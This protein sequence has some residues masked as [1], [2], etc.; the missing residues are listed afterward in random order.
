MTNSWKEWQGR[1][2]DGKF[3]LGT[4]LGGSEGSAVF[5]TRISASGS[6]PA[7][8]SPAKDAKS[9]SKTDAAIKLVVADG[10][11][12]ESPLQRWKVAMSLN[13]PNLLRILAVGRCIVDGREVVYAVEEFSEENL[14][15]V[16]S[17][18][19]LDADETRGTLLPVLAALEYVHGQGL[20]H[21][22]IRPSNILGVENQV[23]LSSDSLRPA[24]E[25]PRS[26]GLYDAPEV[27]TAGISPASDVWCFGMTMV[28]TLTQRVPV[29]DPARMSPPEIEG[30]I[31]SNVPEPF[32]GIAQRCLALD[33]AQRSGVREIAD[34]LRGEPGNQPDAKA[35][36]A[37]VP[38]AGKPARVA[39]IAASDEKTAKWPYLLLLAAAIAVAIFLI[40]R[41]RPSS[42]PSDI[43]SGA[44]NTQTSSAPPPSSPQASS[45]PASP[46]Q[47]GQPTHGEQQSAQSSPSAARPGNASN[48]SD[49]DEIVERATPQVAPS[50][51]RTISGKIKVRVRVVVDPAGNV[52]DAKLKEGGSSK[53]FARLA[54][55]AARRWKFAPAPDANRRDWILLFAFTRARTEMSAARAH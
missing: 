30:E 28:E 9:E 43:Q 33:P 21:G 1:T 25:V 26:I 27:L 36:S 3:V 44:P 10:A 55:E 17:T 22:A 54:V 40:V 5:R 15:Q 53:Y 29:W 14:S 2:V 12:S 46:T 7:G 50:A 13:H 20:V 35:A 38:D 23:K 52:T 41:P 6:G 39:A 24:G 34:R 42:E 48:S 49:A 18:R 51:R 47:A 37:V 31:E 45:P 16:L 19:A 4:Y 11:E 8:G 32:R